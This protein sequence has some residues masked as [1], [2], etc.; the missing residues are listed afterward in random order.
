LKEKALYKSKKEKI[1]NEANLGPNNLWKAVKIVQ[2]K[3]QASYPNEMQDFDGQK[4]KTN[5]EKADAFAKTFAKKSEEV[6][7]EVKIKENEVYNGKRKIFQSQEE[8]WLTK[9]L[10][11]KTLKELKSKRCFGFDRVPLVFFK[12]GASEL[13]EVVTKLMF[14]ILE[15]EKNPEQ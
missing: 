1:R 5:Q 3:N 11:E 15:E 4:L 9:K 7:S 6:V 13:N 14:K 2:E 10:V 12:D 8:D